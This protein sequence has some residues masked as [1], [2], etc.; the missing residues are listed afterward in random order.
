MCAGAGRAA[1]G[2]VTL[3]RVAGTAMAAA[4]MAA[5]A[6]NASPT[7]MWGCGTAMAQRGLAER[8]GAS[9][10]LV[11]VQCASPCARGQ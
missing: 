11:A 7:N 3:A 2:G 1:V 9:S 8:L 6:G 5:G 10:R 4:P